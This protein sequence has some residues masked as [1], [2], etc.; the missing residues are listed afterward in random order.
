M[1]DFNVYM[2]HN[3]DQLN[4]S[5]K[6]LTEFADSIGSNYLCIVCIRMSYSNVDTINVHLDSALFTNEIFGRKYATATH[7]SLKDA[8]E[9]YEIY[10]DGEIAFHN[11]DLFNEGI[12]FSEVN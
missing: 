7:N 4:S 2:V 3:R 9:T 6:E 8:N 12:I 5:I 11:G 1:H 10:Y